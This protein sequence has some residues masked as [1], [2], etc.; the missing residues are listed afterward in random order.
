MIKKMKKRILASII[1]FFIILLFIITTLWWVVGWGT[2][3]SSR[4]S[5]S[6]VHKNHRRYGRIPNP[7]FSPSWPAIDPDEDRDPAIQPIFPIPPLV[8]DPPTPSYWNMHFNFRRLFGRFMPLD[9]TNAQGERIRPTGEHQSIGITASFLSVWSADTVV[10][11]MI[12]NGITNKTVADVR[13]Q[14]TQIDATTFENETFQYIGERSGRVYNNLRVPLSDGLSTQ[15]RYEDVEVGSRKLEVQ[16]SFLFSVLPDVRVVIF[17]YGGVPSMCPPFDDDNL[18]DTEDPANDD[19]YDDIARALYFKAYQRADLFTVFCN[20]VVF[21][22]MGTDH[23]RETADAVHGYIDGIVEEKK[24]FLTTTG[25]FHPDD[26]PGGG[27]QQQPYPV[28]FSNTIRVAPLRVEDLRL[29]DGR[30]I[31]TPVS[32]PGSLGGF[33]N[34]EMNGGR[35]QSRVPYHQLGYVPEDVMQ[36]YYNG[37]PDISGISSNAYVRFTPTVETQTSIIDTSLPVLLYASVMAATNIISGNNCW[38]YRRLIYQYADYLTVPVQRGDALIK[39]YQR[40]NPVTG[41]GQMDGVLLA[42]LLQNRLVSSGHKIQIASSSISRDMSYMNAYPLPFIEDDT[43]PTIELGGG[44]PYKT[45]DPAFGPQSIWSEMSVHHV[46]QGVDGYFRVNPFSGT[47]MNDNVLVVFVHEDSTTGQRYML[48][49]KR[50]RLCFAIC[51]EDVLANPLQEEMIW[52]L[53]L[54]APAGTT[55]IQYFDPIVISPWLSGQQRMSSRYNR[56]AHQSP[57]VYDPTE[58]ETWIAS[59]IFYLCPHTYRLI[60]PAYTEQIASSYY[61]NM[62]NSDDFIVNREERMNDYLSA[63]DACASLDRSREEDTTVDLFFDSGFDPHPQWLMIPNHNAARSPNYI[64]TLTY[65]HFL[66]FNTRCQAYLWVHCHGDGVDRSYY[67]K[68][69]NVNYNTCPVWTTI[70]G[71]TR[72]SIKTRDMPRDFRIFGLKSV[73]QRPAE[74]FNVF[75]SR[76]WIVFH[77]PFYTVYKPEAVY[78]TIDHLGDA[79]THSVEFNHDP[80]PAPNINLFLV[81]DEVMMTSSR[82]NM[83]IV[84]VRYDSVGADFTAMADNGNGS[85]TMNIANAQNVP[86]LQIWMFTPDDLPTVKNAYDDDVII[87]ILEPLESRDRPL[88][89]TN[90]FVIESMATMGGCLVYSDAGSQWKPR[91]GAYDQTPQPDRI[92]RLVPNYNNTPPSTPD[93]SDIRLTSNYVYLNTLYFIMSTKGL[94]ATIAG[95]RPGLLPGVG[96]PTNANY[97]QATF[98]LGSLQDHS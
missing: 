19:M 43:F 71:M 51:D 74:L 53:T 67:L 40:W 72:F 16:L 27:Q 95:N 57:S 89:F 73:P 8:P 14:V 7:P 75:L 39:K 91:V 11:N 38:D 20:T 59:E 85:V 33:F 9:F 22:V 13:S 80:V 81:A 63:R 87:P 10:R 26:I 96:Y 76:V 58:V 28:A 44:I 55:Q 52:R 3:S 12:D 77:D 29:N 62:T 32:Y 50:R 46:F 25:L 4:D 70:R 49:S 88:E 82:R 90:G 48:V 68:L 24:P 69:L 83:M 21:R 15:V 6:T 78:A 56:E 18:P 42:R 5:S 60:N 66:F 86:G 98:S 17:Y 93:M 36:G 97:V 1:S 64:A 31:Q 41:L 61:V 54:S 2:P 92:W 37:V 34:L 35:Y 47:S 30:V 94:L 79:S 84:Q 45:V 65:G 23:S